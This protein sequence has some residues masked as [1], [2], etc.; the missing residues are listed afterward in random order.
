[1]LS[2]HKYTYSR[3]ALRLGPAAAA[4][5]LFAMPACVVDGTTAEPVEQ[6]G[7]VEQASTPLLPTKYLH[8]M[9]CTVSKEVKDKADQYCAALAQQDDHDRSCALHVT[10]RIESGDTKYYVRCGQCDEVI[11]KPIDMMIIKD[12]IMEDKYGTC[13]E[14]R[15]D[16]QQLFFNGRII[17]IEG[18]PPPPRATLFAMLSSFWISTSSMLRA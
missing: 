17:E 8:D 9:N 10:C 12:K 11:D 13:L 15:L 6:I 2:A 16:M 4:L 7:D 3:L 18:L 5:M 14:F 1:M